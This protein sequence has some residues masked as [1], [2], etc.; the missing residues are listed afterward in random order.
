MTFTRIDPNTVQSNGG[1]TV[2]AVRIHDV[3]YSNALHSVTIPGEILV[4]D[5][6]YVI[7]LS[8]LKR[9]DPP[10]SQ[11]S[12]DPAEKKEIADNVVQAL[13]FMGVRFV[14]E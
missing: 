1:F 11:T 5:P 3:K 7:Y 13:Q 10:G 6:A 4:G 14:V 12:I 8:A 2:Q 9:W